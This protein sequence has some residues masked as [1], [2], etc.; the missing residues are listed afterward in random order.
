MVLSELYFIS[1][2]ICNVAREYIG[3]WFS[4]FYLTL[5]N[6]AIFDI[7]S[8]FDGLRSLAMTTHILKDYALLPMTPRILKDYV[9]MP[10]LL[11]FEGL[12]SH[13]NDY[14]HMKDYVLI[15]MTTRILIPFSLT[16][17]LSHHQISIDWYLLA[18]LLYLG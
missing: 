17:L 14:S 13:A 2:C 5:F 8:S 6:A 11:A 4:N 9:L 1:D 18:S 12:C 7:F 3:F 10:R 15:S 16:L